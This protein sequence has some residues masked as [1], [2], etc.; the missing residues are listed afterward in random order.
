MM[1]RRSL[2]LAACALALLS[3]ASLVAADESLGSNFYR[4]RLRAAGGGATAARRQLQDA[5]AAPASSDL[6]VASLDWTSEGG[7][8]LLNGQPF[9]LKGTSW[10]GLETP[11]EGNYKWA[12]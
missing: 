8:I 5:A 10:F 9:H 7:E 2:T 12:G 6:C 4:P 1:R 3:S 11:N